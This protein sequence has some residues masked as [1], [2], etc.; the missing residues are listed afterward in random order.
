MAPQHLLGPLWAPSLRVS[1]EFPIRSSGV[2]GF[3]KVSLGMEGAA[4]P[5]AG[6]KPWP[7]QARLQDP[8]ERQ[9]G[10]EKK[11]HTRPHG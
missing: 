2:L 1:K 9:Q 6:P 5:T 8:Q 3:G 7:G 4:L 11:N 10:G